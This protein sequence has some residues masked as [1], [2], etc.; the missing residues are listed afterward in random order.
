MITSSKLGQVTNF[1]FIYISDSPIT[2]N[3]AVKMTSLQ[4]LYFTG[5]DDATIN[6]LRDSS[7]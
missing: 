1:C 5:G 6:S 3:F 7:L 2:T 4:L